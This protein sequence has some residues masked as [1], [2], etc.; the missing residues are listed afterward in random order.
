MRDFQCPH[1]LRHTYVEF[2][3]LWYY[4]EGES[5]LNLS[6][7][8]GNW[9]FSVAK[10][11]ACGRMVLHLLDGRTN[12]GTVVYP[13]NLSRPPLSEHVPERYGEDYEEAALVLTDSPKASAA[14]SR[15][16]LQNILREEAKVKHGTLYAEIQAAIISGTLPSHITDALDTLRQLGNTAAHPTKNPNTGE[17]VPVDPDEA[18]WCL[19]VLDM[20][21]DFCFVAPAKAAERKRALDAKKGTSP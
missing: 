10:C 12:A 18:S 21:F 6:A 4:E 19:D 20:L 1:C 16:C 13:R 7:E 11:P 3:D 8:D 17:I 9:H 15:R 2:D 5:I 14:L